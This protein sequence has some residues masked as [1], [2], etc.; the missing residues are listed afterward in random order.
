MSKSK[1][2]VKG[3]DITV[4]KQENEDFIS[5]TDV[6]KSFEGGGSLIEN[7]LKNKDTLLFL[8]VWEQMNNQ[9]FNSLE[10][11]GI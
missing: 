8:G 4:L 11:E 6:V 1:I 2:N 10:L 9:N 3:T 7:W 5:L